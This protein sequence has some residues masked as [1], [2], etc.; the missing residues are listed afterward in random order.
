MS[1]VVSFRL[2]EGNPRERQALEALRSWNEAGYSIRHTLTEALLRLEGKEEGVTDELKL[3]LA[4][5]AA[6]LERVELRREVPMLESADLSEAFL[7]SVREA[8]RPGMR[9]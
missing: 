9:G 6:A 5:V 7:E 2:D 8:A 1:A 3:L 4:Q